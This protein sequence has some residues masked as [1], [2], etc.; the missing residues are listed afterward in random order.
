MEATPPTKTPS[1]GETMVRC[2]TVPVES[3]TEKHNEIEP[4]TSL[5]FHP[6]FFP[7]ILSVLTT[8]RLS[9]ITILWETV[10]RSGGISLVTAPR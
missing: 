1:G 6:V 10:T 2:G 8:E 7:F 3:N 9:A 4:A 5:L